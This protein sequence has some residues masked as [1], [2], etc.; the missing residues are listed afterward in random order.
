MPSGSN[1]DD[2]RIYTIPGIPVSALNDDLI[3]EIYVGQY[4]SIVLNIGSSV[5]DG[6][7]VPQGTNDPND[8]SSWQTLK[9]TDMISLD[10]EDTSSAGFDNVQNRVYG[11]IRS[12]TWFRVRMIE[13]TSGTA[14]GTLQLYR[15][16]LPG[17]Q[18]QYVFMR[19]QYGHILRNSSAI[20]LPSGVVTADGDSGTLQN[21]NAK[22]V[23]IYITPGALGAGAVGLTVTIQELDLA[24]GTYYN[25]LASTALV[26]STPQVLKLYP[27]IPVAANQSANDFLPNTWLVKWSATMWG[28][29]GSTLGISCAL[30][31]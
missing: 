31:E 20:I 19:A 26:A 11:C 16:G 18:L 24:S 13:Y 30:N 6:L 23:R 21:L 17:F 4:G 8:S 10:S 14:Q 7:L 12:Y 5:Y 1:V 3:S 15:D 22:G 28:T 29:G 25:L 9:M 27:G 2:G